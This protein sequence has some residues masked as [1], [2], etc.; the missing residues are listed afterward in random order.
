[1]KLLF[2][3][4]FL[5]VLSCNTVKKEYVCGD[6]LCVDKKEFNEY[7]S[8]NLTIEIQSQKKEIKKIDLA[9][10]NTASSNENKENK[11]FSKKKMR[12]KN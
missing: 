4:F 3:F 9:K 1:M 8:K 11:K 7:F 2:P 5:L 10:L 6:H 12:R